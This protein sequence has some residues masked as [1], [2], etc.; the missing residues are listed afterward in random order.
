MKARTERV[1]GYVWC[2]DHGSIHEDTTDPYGYG[3]GDPDTCT[4][5]QHRIVLARMRAADGPL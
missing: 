2:L 1:E 3:A 5:D 4:A